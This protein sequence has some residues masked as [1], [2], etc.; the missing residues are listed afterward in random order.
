MGKRL[1]GQVIVP[2]GRSPRS[3]PALACVGDQQREFGD[4]FGPIERAHP[5]RTL[6]VL[7]ARSRALLQRG[8]WPAAAPSDL[9]PA[10][11]LALGQTSLSGNPRLGDS[12]GI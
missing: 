6:R 2:P 9:Q 8:E 12:A 7:L 3:V 5:D 10:Q 1:S 4:S 11:L